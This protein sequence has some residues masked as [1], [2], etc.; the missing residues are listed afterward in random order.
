M[1]RR[2]L[3]TMF[4]TTYRT[5]HSVRLAPSIRVEVRRF[6]R[7]I[8]GRGRRLLS[9]L[10]RSHL[11]VR[12]KGRRESFLRAILE[13]MGGRKAMLMATGRRQ[14]RFECTLLLHCS[15]HISQVLVINKIPASTVIE[16]VCRICVKFWKQIH[17][18]IN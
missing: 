4:Q 14:G 5:V 10:L 12:R 15:A 16:L 2:C 17:I 3:F 8:E 11:Q 1:A 13:L 7:S 18:T 6:V 9:L